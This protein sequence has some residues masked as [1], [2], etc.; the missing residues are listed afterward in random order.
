[1]IAGS[2]TACPAVLTRSP[3]AR[4]ARPENVAGFV[5]RV[6]F[7]FSGLRFLSGGWFG[8]PFEFFRFATCMF[9]GRAAG[10]SSFGVMV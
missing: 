9:I 10:S 7:V 4:R 2:K 6:L 1:M 8:V 3:W 5:Y